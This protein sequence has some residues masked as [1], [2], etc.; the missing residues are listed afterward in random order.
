MPC[1]DPRDDWTIRQ[2]EKS[3]SNVPKE[4]RKSNLKIFNGGGSNIEDILGEV[5]KYVTYLDVRTDHLTQLLCG[6]MTICETMIVHHPKLGDI[7]IGA[8]LC[9]ENEKLRDWWEKHKEFDRIRKE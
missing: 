1:R 4:N 5:T 9:Y 2:W 7:N 6:V 8:I 3:N